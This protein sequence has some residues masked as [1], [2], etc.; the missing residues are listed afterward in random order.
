MGGNLRA[1]RSN[2]HTLNPSQ[3]NFV[4]RQGTFALDLLQPRL[5]SRKAI[6]L[7]LHALLQ[8]HM[9][10]TQHATDLRWWQPFIEQKCNLF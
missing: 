1:R 8:F 5:D 10:Q 9:F 6:L 4:E 7:R 2:L 3:H